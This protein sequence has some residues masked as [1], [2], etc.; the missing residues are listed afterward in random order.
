MRYGLFVSFILHSFRTDL[1]RIFSL[2]PYGTPCERHG[3]KN[4]DFMLELSFAVVILCRTLISLSLHFLSHTYKTR[5]SNMDIL[6]FVEIKVDQIF[7]IE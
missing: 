2:D 1:I 4:Y 7:R 6:G 5:R 3:V